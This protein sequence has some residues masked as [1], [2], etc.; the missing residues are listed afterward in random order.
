[1]P[2]TARILFSLMAV[3]F[4]VWAVLM[5]AATGTATAQ[6]ITTWATPVPVTPD[7]P[8]QVIEALV[9]AIVDIL[10]QILAELIGARG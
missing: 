6:D 8:A 1:M 4:V 5:I 2:I 7:V 9:R 3:A 10:R